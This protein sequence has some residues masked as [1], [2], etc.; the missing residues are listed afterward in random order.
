MRLRAALAVGTAPEVRFVEVL[1]ERCAVE[2]EFF[3]RDMLTWAL[4]RHPV[5]VTLPA[6]L[7]EVR[8]ERAQARSQALH[9]LSKIGDRRAWSAITEAV[10]SDLDDD[11]A[12]SAWR[13]AVVLVPAGEEAGLATAL[14]TQLGRGSRETQLS[15]SRALVAL[16]SPTP[17]ALPTPPAS[18]TSPTSSASPTSPTSPTETA[19]DAAVQPDAA[20]LSA[21]RTASTRPDPRARTHAL[22][23]ERLL[24][25]P[26]AGFEFAV[27]E[28]KRIVALGGE[29]DRRTGGQEARVDRVDR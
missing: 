23:T 28:A 19:P 17:S 18:L 11:V 9:T 15:L 29:A 7:R 27:E 5:S 3:V 16:A 4:T 26:D 25:D 2:P 10:L 12:R 22:A 14:A 13:A 24:R 20:V 1:V 6:L 21:L 8:S